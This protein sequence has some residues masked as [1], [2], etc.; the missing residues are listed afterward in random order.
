MTKPTNVLAIALAA[1]LM[2]TAADAER[3]SLDD[4]QAP[5][6]QAVQALRDRTDDV[7]APRG[8]AVQAL[9]DR[10]DDVEAPR[11]TGA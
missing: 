11:G 4:V 2:V 7:E 10:T 8:Q 1:A 3:S 6:G 9:R 5:R